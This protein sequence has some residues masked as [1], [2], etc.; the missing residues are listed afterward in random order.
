MSD[1]AETQVQRYL[2]YNATAPLRA[3]ALDAMWPFLHSHHGNSQSVHRAGRFVRQAVEHARNQIARLVGCQPEEVIF[4][5]GAT[6]S[7]NWA[8]A[9][10]AKGRPRL[11]GQSEHDA[12]LQ[13]VPDAERL[14]VDANGVVT[15]E[16]LAS[17]RKGQE[18]ALISIMW[19]NNE[20][21]VVNDIPALAR[22]AS[23]TGDMLHSDAVQ[24]I[25][26]VP[27]NFASSGLAAMSV[28]SHKIG[29]PLGVGALIV[30]RGVEIL[31][32]QRGGGHE[33]GRRAGTLNVPA[34][35][36]FGAAAELLRKEGLLEAEQLRQW[37]DDFESALMVRFPQAEV[38]GRGAER[39]PNTSFFALPGWHSEALLMA[40]DKRGFALASGS[41]CHS[42]TDIPSHVLSAMGVPL[43]RALGA[44]RM[45]LGHG[46]QESE[47]S[48]LLDALVAID[49][50]RGAGGAFAELLNA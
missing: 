5:G 46:S 22:M 10:L 8:L 36:G 34:I 45:S 39:L 44:V 30:R 20:T 50:S 35:V 25:G 40:L 41:A 49:Q 43:E 48:D 9:G 37:R 26:R 4:T 11:V 1:V 42:G 16:A 28:S 23:S 33:G 15:T 32:G 38:F 13:A 27:V 7:D 31:S 47:L 29:G 2:D 14:P 6:E 17:I 12:V 3:D 24:A 19:A 18:P 21:G